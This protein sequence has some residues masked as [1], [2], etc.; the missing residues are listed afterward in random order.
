MK[1]LE[2]ICTCGAKLEFVEV[3]LWRYGVECYS[4]EKRWALEAFDNEEGE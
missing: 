4:C 1:P 2:F 3:G